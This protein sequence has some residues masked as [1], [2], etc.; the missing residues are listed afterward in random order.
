[1]NPTVLSIYLAL[2]ALLA[3][4]G[5]KTRPGSIGVFLLSVIFTPLLVGSILALARPVPTKSSS[6]SINKS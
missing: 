5:R 3:V 6:K 2:C 1:M 4:A